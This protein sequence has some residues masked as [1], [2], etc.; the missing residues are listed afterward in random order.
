MDQDEVGRPKSGMSRRSLIKR[1]AIVGGLVWTPPV[2]QSLRIPANAQE[3]PPGGAG[4]DLC[5]ACIAATFDPPGAPPPVTQ[6]IE[7]SPSTTCCD[8]IAANGGDLFAVLGCAISAIAPS[9]AA[10]NPDPASR[11]SVTDDELQQRRATRGVPPPRRASSRPTT[12]GMSRSQPRRR[13]SPR[14]SRSG[15]EPLGRAPAPLREL[16]HEFGDTI[17]RVSEMRG[18]HAEAGASLDGVGEHA[19]RFGGSVDGSSA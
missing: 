5:L 12:G 16:R 1:G 10:C 18:G 17:D 6:H 2:V 4:S 14:R 19:K 15:S 9:S 7:F 8:C 11:R 13:R 3:A